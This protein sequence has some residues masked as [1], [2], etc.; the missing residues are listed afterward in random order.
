MERFALEPP[1]R[2]DVFDRSKRLIPTGTTELE[3]GTV[4][5]FRSGGCFIRRR[6]ARQ[7]RDGQR[8][9]IGLTRHSDH[10]AQASRPY[11]D[12]RYYVESPTMPLGYCGTM[13]LAIMH[14]DRYQAHAKEEL[15]RLGLGPYRNGGIAGS[16]A[17][18]PPATAD[19][20]TA[21]AM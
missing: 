17:P 2:I 9:L 1:F 10:H 18:S 3:P 4:A 8:S 5:R 20:P 11:Q 13:L 19:A 14:N 16:D 15:R 6:D 21:N 12:L 7:I